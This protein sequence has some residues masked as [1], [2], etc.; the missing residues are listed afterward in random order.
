M[1]TN[2][3]R[4]NSCFHRHPHPQ[5]LGQRLL[6]IQHDSHRNPLHDFREVAGRVVRLDRSK[7]HT[8]GRSNTLDAAA[9]GF[10]TKGIHMHLY[11]LPRVHVRQLGFLKI[12][13]HIGLPQRHHR[14]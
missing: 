11:T 10:T 13:D 7:S 3:R 4:I 1:L 14:Q 8:S 9:Q 6:R 12:G 5:P 2:T